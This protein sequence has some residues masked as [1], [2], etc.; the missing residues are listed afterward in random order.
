MDS[1]NSQIITILAGA[2]G[3][4]GTELLKEMLEDGPITRIYALTR[5]P[6]P[7]FH[8][9]LETIQ[10]EQLQIH[11]WDEDKPSPRYGFICLGTTKQQ[12]GSSAE[13]KKIDYDLVCDVARTMKVIGVTHLSVVSSLGASSTS[14]SHYL[15]CKGNMEVTLSRMKFERLVFVRPG[16]LLGL[17]D[18]PRTGEALTQH[19]LN[20]LSPVMLG[21]LRNLVPIEARKVALAMLFSL[22]EPSNQ[23]ISILNTVDILTLLHKYNYQ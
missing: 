8:T 2:S 7:Y 22:L 6:L 5:Q 4:V 13:L 1:D 12:A 19:A 14:L 15:R 17:R 18:K 10:N 3:L 20:V 21:S 23:K 11:E 9:K 16:P